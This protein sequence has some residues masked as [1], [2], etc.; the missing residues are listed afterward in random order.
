MRNDAIMNDLNEIMKYSASSNEAT[1]NINNSI[2]NNN[3]NTG[4]YNY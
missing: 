4:Y 1:Y 3:N 2:N